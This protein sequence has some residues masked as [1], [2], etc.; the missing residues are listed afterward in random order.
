MEVSE[1]LHAPTVLPL[2]KQLSVLILEE[3]LSPR[4]EK[5]LAPLGL[6][7]R[8]LGNPARSQSLYRQRYQISDLKYI[9][10]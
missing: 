9:V 4:E 5:I 10:T 7:V 8:L 1:E 6:D 2:E 3:V